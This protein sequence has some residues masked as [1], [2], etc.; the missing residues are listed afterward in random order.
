LHY[1]LII[2]LGA[3]S[4]V[5]PA[6]ADTVG[7]ASVIDGDTI[8]VRGQ[9]IRFH[10]IDAPEGRQSCSIEGKPWRCGQQSAQALS[11]LIGTKTIR[12]ETR[13]RDRYRR[14]VAVCHLGGQ[15]INAWMVRNGWAVDYRQYSKGA[16]RA[17]EAQAKQER[18]GIWRGEFQMP[19]DW[20]REMRTGASG[21]KKS[22]SPPNRPANNCR[23]KGNIS[24]RGD[25]IYHVPGGQY[26]SRT[27]INTS[28]GERWF[29]TEAEARAAGWRRSK[30]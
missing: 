6:H 3:F 24:S 16:Y 11:N 19:W 21:K 18:L 1:I 30:R 10:G 15:N 23:I 17:E 29:C 9:R 14:L 25:R 27:R 2:F 8:E 28:K 26:Y 22:T 4:S 12:C 20:R 13:D 5:W 7:R